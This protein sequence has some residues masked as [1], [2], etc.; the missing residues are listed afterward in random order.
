VR[1][2]RPVFYGIERDFGFASLR[3]RTGRQLGIALIGGNLRLGGHSDAPENG[4]A[5]RKDMSLTKASIRNV[6][7]GP[8][9]AGGSDVS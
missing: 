5:Q 4:M 2:V 3:R 8:A 7:T 1:P 6:E 9:R